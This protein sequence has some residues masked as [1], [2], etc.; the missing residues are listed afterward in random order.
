MRG[1]TFAILFTG[2]AVS[3]AIEDLRKEQPKD[4][5][6]QAF[7]GAVSFVTALLFFTA[8]VCTIMGV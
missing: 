2:L 7:I 3:I 8:I 4:S 6:Y 1:I 5:S